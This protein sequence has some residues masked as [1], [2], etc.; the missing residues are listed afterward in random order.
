[1]TNVV[2][3]N[4][5]YDVP[6]KLYSSHLLLMAL[7]LIGPDLPRLA[8]LLW[9]HRPAPAALEPPVV[10]SPRFRPTAMVLKL[11]IVGWVLGSPV[12][13]QL[14]QGEVDAT[15]FGVT[16][17]ELK[18]IWQVETFTRDGALVP[19]LATDP[20]RWSLLIIGD[21]RIMQVRG[22]N[23]Q[24]IDFFLVERA[25]ESGAYTL[26]KP[27]ADPPPRPATITFP[28]PGIMHLATTDG[29]APLAVTLHRL[30]ESTFLLNR[31][32]FHWVSERAYNR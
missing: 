2:L 29:S 9:H 23:G 30:D 21:Y 28:Q 17:P 24:R 13:R 14:Q 1:M 31:R 8:A 18:G 32:G 22:M 20:T 26:S 4:L 19:P 6:V 16:P 27:G 10:A 3:L 7:W 5:C 15:R 12:Y 25:G 11:M